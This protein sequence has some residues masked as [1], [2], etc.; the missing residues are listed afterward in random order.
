MN[1]QKNY[2]SLVRRQGYKYAPIEFGLSPSFKE[3]WDKMLAGRTVAEY[4]D[5]PEGFQT[6][7]PAGVAPAER[8][9]VNWRGFYSED[10]PAG[11][12]F[13]ANYGIAHVPGTDGSHHFTRMLHPLESFDSLEQFQQYPW[14]DFVNCR[15]GNLSKEVKTAHQQGF[16]VCVGTGTIWELAWGLRSMEK[17]MMDM[18]DDDPKAAWLL[19][20]LAD[21]AC[22]V[23]GALTR[24]GVDVIMCGDDVGTQRGLMM[25]EQFYCEWLKPRLARMIKTAKTINPDV[26]IN[27]HSDGNILE[28]I[29]HWIEVG[30]D[31][32]NPV[33]PECLDFAKIHQ[34]FGSRLSF[35]GSIGT[36]TTLPFGT[37]A[38]VRKTV[39][40]NLEI[41][42]RAGGLICHPS[43][44][45]EPEV[46]VENFAAYVKACKE[47]SAVA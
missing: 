33:Q 4:F 27:Y 46:P 41:A 32:L 43:H 2:L 30:V 7:W 37:P 6:R 26:I 24:A 15:I 14:P 5:Y 44:C 47:Y 13:D 1:L 3:R 28:L 19:D 38:D 39:L 17:M 36:Q 25:S 40:R 22:H 45:I 11:T 8:V 10:L 42:G 31:I 21:D 23:S 12:T 20:K 34:E 18:C 35:A 16:A 29:P 9:A